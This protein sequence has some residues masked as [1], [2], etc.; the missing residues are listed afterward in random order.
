[1][2]TAIRDS[3]W[4]ERL[5][6]AVLGLYQQL[7]KIPRV[8]EDWRV[9]VRGAVRLASTLRDQ[10]KLALLFRDLATLRTKEPKITSPEDV[11]WRGP[12]PSFANVCGR[13]DAAQLFEKVTD[14]AS[15]SK[16]KVGRKP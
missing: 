11:Y 9:R 5:A 1:M 6:A 16:A 15:A 10:F 12:K 13:L 3:G 14:L 2:L 8:A 7:E 4:G